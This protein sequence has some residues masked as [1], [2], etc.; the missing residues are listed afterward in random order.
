[1]RK[2]SDRISF[3]SQ[4]LFARDFGIIGHESVVMAAATAMMDTIVFGKRRTN[5]L[6]ESLRCY[7]LFLRYLLFVI[8]EVARFCYVY[9]YILFIAAPHS[10]SE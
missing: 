2:Q 6:V 9:Y 4:I 10:C 8:A 3:P 5:S 1:M 7:R